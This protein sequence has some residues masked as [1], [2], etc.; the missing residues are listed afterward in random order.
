M[1][2]RR[3]I[4]LSVKLI[5]TAFVAVLIPSYWVTYTPWNF[6]FFCDVAL[7]IT[8]VALW[9]ESPLLASIP[10]VGIILAQIVWVIDFCIGGR[11]GLAAYMFD[12]NQPLHLRALSTFHGWLPF[13]LIWLIHR[14]G[15]ARRAF[16]TQVG[17]TWGLILVAYNF[18]PP[19]PAS[20]DSPNMAVNINYV[21]GPS[22]N[23]SQTWMAPHLWVATLMVMLPI[24]L[25]IPT[26]FVLL[27]CFPIRSLESILNAEIPP[28]H[29]HESGDRLDLGGYA[30]TGPD[31]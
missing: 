19:P 31:G 9:S 22:F 5:Y 20:G 8:L 29:D 6:L 15:Y 2:T 17:L 18:G 7:L 14:H 21:F 3:K 25:Y 26:H 23:Q 16:I 4:P 27:R 13:L 11:I 30:F 24:V 12:P 1:T 28:V 10:A